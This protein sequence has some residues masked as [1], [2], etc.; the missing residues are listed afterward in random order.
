MAAATF[1]A[2]AFVVLLTLRPLRFAPASWPAFYMDDFFYYVVIARN[3][4]AHGLS[5]F[6]GVT[7]TNGYHPLWMLVISFLLLIGGGAGRAFFLLL[8]TVQLLAYASAIWQVAALLIRR[9]THPGLTIAVTLIFAVAFSTTALTGMEVILAVPLILAFIAEAQRAGGEGIRP[10][11]F[12][13]LASACIF[14]R[15]D[16]VILVVVIALAVLPA[17]CK[18]LRQRAGL[19]LCL[20]LAPSALYFCINA[21]VFGAILPLSSAAKALAPSLFFNTGPVATPLLTFHDPVIACMITLPAWCILVCAIAGVLTWRSSTQAARLRTS[22]CAFPVLFY[23][24]LAVRSDW[25]L[26]EWYLYPIVIAL[27]F[28][29]I[30]ISGFLARTKAI[31]VTPLAAVAGLLFGIVLATADVA[32]HYL[33]QG[34]DSNAMFTQASALLPFMATHRGTYAMGDQAGTPAFLSGAPIFQLEGLVEDREL[35][36]DIARQ[37]PLL[38]VLRKRGVRYYI[39]TD[40]PRDGNCW[41]GIEPKRRQAGP[42]SPAMTGRFCGTPVFSVKGA[43]SGNTLIFDM[44]AVGASAPPTYSN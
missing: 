3:F 5:S 14:A 35:L 42:L 37:A 1:P 15:V 17:L 31:S 32:A 9:R 40:M 16:A 36:R 29:F 20:G 7:P 44:D 10:L 6:D 38:S 22:I 4:V 23:L 39:G 18:L 24:A 41:I 21:A 34:P 12:G 28:A 30:T 19:R 13:L 2:L 25:I 43:G 33:H 8:T 26:W 27:P 11:R